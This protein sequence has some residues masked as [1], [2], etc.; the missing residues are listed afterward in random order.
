MVTAR[1]RAARAG[2]LSGACDV[3]DGRG[4][5][6]GGQMLGLLVLAALAY[7]VLA[8]GVGHG[9]G[10]LLSVDTQGAWGVR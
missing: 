4:R 5:F 7:S 9:L 6:G 10:A 8:F 1:T 3:Y 2:Q